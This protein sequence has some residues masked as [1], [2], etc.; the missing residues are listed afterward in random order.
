[1]SSLFVM[2]I[3]LSLFYYLYNTNKYDN[4]CKIPPKNCYINLVRS[5][6]VPPDDNS[7]KCWLAFQNGAFEDAKKYNGYMN[8]NSMVSPDKTTTSSYVT[9]KT[10]EEYDKWQSI[11]HPRGPGVDPFAGQ[12]GVLLKNL[13]HC[14]AEHTHPTTK[15]HTIV[16]DNTDN[17]WNGQWANNSCIQCPS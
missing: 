16:M 11:Y 14:M 12:H 6:S 9:F 17:N 8:S 7:R 5:E 3:I 10:Q 1:M 15:N 2:V 13:E 4:I